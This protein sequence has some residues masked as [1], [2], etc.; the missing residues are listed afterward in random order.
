MSKIGINGF[1]RIGPLLLRHL[2]ETRTAIPWSPSATSPP[3]VQACLPRHDSNYGGFPERG[4]HQRDALIVDG[5][6]IA[7]VRR[8]E[9]KHIPWKAAEAWMY[10]VVECN[11]VFIPLKRNYGRTRTPARKKVL[12]IS[13]CG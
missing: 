7:V 4:F 13:A 10:I 2:L 9:A 12:T 6:T 8:K 1:G 3:K 11:P 5:K